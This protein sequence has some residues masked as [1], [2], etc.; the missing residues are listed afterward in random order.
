ME[1]RRSGGGR[2]L[3]FDPIDFEDRPITAQAPWPIGY[4][5][6]EP[7][8]QRACDWAVCGRAAFN[9][10]EIPEIAERDLVAGLPDGDVRT[11]DL[12]R[13]AL[14]T[15]F[16]RRYRAA[17]RDSPHLTLWTG[18]TC[19][20]IVTSAA[21]DTVDHLVVKSLN[22]GAGRVVATDYVIATGGLEATRL[23]LASDRHHPGGAGERGRAPGA[24]VHGARRGPGR[25][26]AIH[27]R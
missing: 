21:G 2:C 3:E 8:L 14:P 17:L 24:L 22:G 15:R 10:R 9:A 26:R 16:G 20:E 5:D 18:L 6:V 7:Y 13:W 27:H 12:E 11:T 1:P 4:D 23:L 19:T 25:A